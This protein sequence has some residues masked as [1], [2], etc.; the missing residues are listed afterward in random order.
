LFRAFRQE[1][2]NV[3]MTCGG[4]SRAVETM[5][6]KVAGVE[7]VETDVE[8]KYVKVTGTAS[9]DDILKAI[10]KTGKAVSDWSG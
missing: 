6:K 3:A 5:V 2:F 9:R 10:K 7:S 1:E 8:K 4:C